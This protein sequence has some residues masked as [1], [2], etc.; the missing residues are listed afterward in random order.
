[1]TFSRA[2]VRRNCLSEH[3]GQERLSSSRHRAEA[4]R[5]LEGQALA[6]GIFP[7]CSSKGQGAEGQRWPNPV[8]LQPPAPLAQ[9][10]RALGTAGW[11]RPVAAR[12]DGAR[13]F[14]EFVCLCS[15]RGEEI[16]WR[17]VYRPGIVP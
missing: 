17:G 10:W 14:L 3:G 6:P 15:N 2:R 7:G 12:E 9:S 5:C 1:M 13:H 4:G 11:M 16:P 8:G